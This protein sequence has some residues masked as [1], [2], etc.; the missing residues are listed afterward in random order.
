MLRWLVYETI[1]RLTGSEADMKGRQTDRLA[2]IGRLAGE[3]LQ[4]EG[5]TDCWADRQ[6]GGQEHRGYVQTDL[7]DRNIQTDRH[8]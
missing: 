8:G 3:W 5:L 7:Q 6:M 4:T 1:C 2:Q